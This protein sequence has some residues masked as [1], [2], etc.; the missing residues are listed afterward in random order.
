MRN[1]GTLEDLV[2]S[3]NYLSF[4]SF[5][6]LMSTSVCMHEPTDMLVYKSV[7]VRV[8]E[9]K[10]FYPSSSTTLFHANTY[11]VSHVWTTGATDTEDKIK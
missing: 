1:R 9:E 10:K 6:I 4:F 2:I 3:G 11:T 5:S 7:V 8:P